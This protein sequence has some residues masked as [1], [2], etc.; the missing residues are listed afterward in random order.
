MCIRDSS[1]AS[2]DELHRGKIEQLL[3]LSKYHDFAK[4]YRFANV[5]QRRFLDLYFMHY[6]I[7]I[8]KTCLRNAA[9]NRESAQDLSGFKE[10]FDKHSDMDLV[11]LLVSYTHLDVYKRQVL[12]V[13]ISQSP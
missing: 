9:G 5:G 13:F 1:K 10:F 8:L 11:Q 7:D 4:L 3:N 6:E 2:E 12:S